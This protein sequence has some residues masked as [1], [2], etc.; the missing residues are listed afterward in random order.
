[1]MNVNR[2][3]GVVEWQTSA[4]NSFT[5]STGQAHKTQAK[6]GQVVELADTPALGAG[7]ARREGSTPSL[8]TNSIRGFY[9]VVN[10]KR[11]TTGRVLFPAHSEH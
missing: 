6:F 5:I 9:P 3:A 1:M 10:V 4:L 2:H 8:P 7:A 11:Y